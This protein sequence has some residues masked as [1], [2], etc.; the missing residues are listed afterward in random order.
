MTDD[1]ARNL[2]SDLFYESGTAEDTM[3]RTF[4]SS[5]KDIAYQLND[6]V[7][8]VNQLT[9]QDVIELL[10]EMEFA[11][12]GR[13]SMNVAFSAFKREPDV[14][15]A[16]QALLT[17]TKK[18]YKNIRNDFLNAVKQKIIEESKNPDGFVRKWL[19]GEQGQ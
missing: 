19:I 8:D 13:S 2:L 4:K 6:G 18:Q 7:L 10:R 5:K 17:E 9:P 14:K 16:V 3:S 12:R 1:N 15:K 11:Y